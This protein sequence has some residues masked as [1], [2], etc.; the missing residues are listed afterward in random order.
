MRSLRQHVAAMEVDSEDALVRVGYKV[1]SQA[2][3]LAPVDT[4]RL[5][6]SIILTRG[7]DGQGFYVEVGTNVYYARF[8]EF[9]TRYTNAQP[10]LI[11]AVALASGYL[12]QEA[13]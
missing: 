6:S 3:I 5:R 8:V 11:P 10:F 2:R 7:R 9:G 12:R 1:M 13:A 4:G